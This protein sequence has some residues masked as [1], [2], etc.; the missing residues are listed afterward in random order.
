MK[1]IAPHGGRLIDRV[2]VGGERQKLLARA[3]RMPRVRLNERERSD[4][5]MI[6]CGAMSPLE[7]FM[8]QANYHSVIDHKCLIGGLPWTI[9]ISLSLKEDAGTDLRTGQEAALTDAAGQVLAILEISDIFPHDKDKEAMQVYGTTDT[10]HPGVEYVVRQMGKALLGGRVHVLERA[11]YTEFN[12][13]RRDPADLRQM[14]SERGWR[15]VVGYQTRNPIHRAHEYIM[16]AALEI[17]DGLLIH[18]LMGQ[19]KSD[20]VPASVRMKV[21]EYMVQEYYPKDRVVLAVFPAAMRYGG[22]RE[23]V[24]HAILRQNYGCTHFIVGRDHAGVSIDGKPFY[25]SF[26]AH[27]IFDEFDPDDL[28]ITP[29]FFDHTFYCRACEGMASY[30]TCPHDSSHH[31]AISGTKVRE[32]LR[33]GQ[34]PPPEFSRPGVAKILIEAMQQRQAYNI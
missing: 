15:R 9:P 7:G 3:E 34:F 17:C 4:L 32:L 27:Y 28:G 29:L 10:K 11:R 1:V 30:K 23:A 20:D 18:P 31:V 12:D 2:V 26:D 24:F 19:T 22:P 16:K 21:Y 25:G 8:D 13:R 33:N 5:D 6:A 14:I